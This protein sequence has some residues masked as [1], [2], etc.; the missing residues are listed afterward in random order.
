MRYTIELD[1]DELSL[2]KGLVR[3]EYYRV[4]EKLK[5]DVF[6]KNSIKNIMAKLLL[7]GGKLDNIIPVA[8]KITK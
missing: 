7:V 2:L 5:D 4:G 1:K 8:D 6:D 3:Q